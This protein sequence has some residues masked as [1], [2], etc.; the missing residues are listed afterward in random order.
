MADSTWATLWA[1]VGARKRAVVDRSSG[2]GSLQPLSALHPTAD[3][4]RR[5]AI[6]D[7]QAAVMR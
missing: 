3:I 2:I 1:F 7:R 4:E 6:S 5:S